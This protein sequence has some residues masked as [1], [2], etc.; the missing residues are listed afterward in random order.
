[1]SIQTNSPKAWLLAS[2]PKTLTAALLPI[3]P[4]TALAVRDG[5]FALV[6]VLLCALFACLM[7]VAANFIN[8]LYDYRKGTDR[9]DRLGPER[10]CA[11]GW[12]TPRAMTAGIVLTLL[13]ACATG[14][15]LL[16]SVCGKLPYSGWEL[17]TLGALCVV[18]AFLYTTRL[19][20]LGWG[21]LLVVVFF[22]FVPVCG[23][24]YVQACTLT[25]DVLLAALACG[26]AT[27]TLLI[28]NN[29]RDREQDAVS[30]K[31]T[32]VVRLGEPFGR[33]L[34]LWAGIAAT[35]LCLWIVRGNGAIAFLLPLVYLALHVRTWQKMSRI[36]SGKKLNSILGET[37]RN[38]L[39]MGILLSV[40]ILL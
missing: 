21:D 8:D 37:S 1:M 39:F 2:R 13:L 7:Q 11:Q 15:G 24:Y 5:H 23:T 32:L 14:L 26:V 6:P 36:R 10:A 33:Q 22:G 25:P 12:I 38:M 35:L 28:V 27:D 16:A 34:Y 4:G 31:R 18:F 29:Y 19:S 17:I 3:L 30:G 9:E 20:Y 40:A